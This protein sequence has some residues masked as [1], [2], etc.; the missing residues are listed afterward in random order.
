M[1][2]KTTGPASKPI[3]L[4]HLSNLSSE[5]DKASPG[6]LLSFLFNPCAYVLTCKK[7]CNAYRDNNVAE[8]KEPSQH[9]IYK[10]WYIYVFK[11]VGEVHIYTNTCKY[12]AEKALWFQLRCYPCK[13]CSPSCRSVHRRKD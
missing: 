8:T 13:R 7:D 12:C 6:I 4:L 3:S 10:Y 2:K 5:G 1:R 9:N 11:A